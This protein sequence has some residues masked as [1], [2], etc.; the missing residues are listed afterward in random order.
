MTAIAE[1]VPAT[2]SLESTEQDRI[3]RFQRSERLLHWAIAVPFM[4][5]YAT[6][7]VLI[8]VYNPNPA[9]PFR[10]VISWLHRGSGVSL[11]V[12]PLVAILTH[13]RDFTLHLRNVR[14]AWTW[15][16]SDLKWLVLFGPSTFNPRIAKPDQGKFNAGEKINFMVLVS[17][18]PVYIAT[19]LLLWLPGVSYVAWMIHFFM[20][21]FIATPLM[22]GHVFLATVNPDTRVGLGGM[23]SG[24]V[25]RHWARN[26]Y[27]YWYEEHFE[28]EAPAAAAALS[29]PC[30]GM[31]M[32]QSCEAVSLAAAW[33]RRYQSLFPAE[34]SECPHRRADGM[35]ARG[36]AETDAAVLDTCDAGEA[37]AAMVPHEGQLHRLPVSVPSR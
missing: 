13:W 21:A 30:A 37:S 32:C 24:F 29:D 20:A 34:V 27:R 1:T 10:W 14:E 31:A 9:R 4:V 6:A 23:F 26:H 2:M 5:C 16:L 18:I 3:L 36:L 22:W 15:S 7:A 17:T 33:A 19:G 11:I 12:L 35:A 28:R 8:T 25:D